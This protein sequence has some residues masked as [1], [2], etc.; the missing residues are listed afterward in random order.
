[1]RSKYQAVFDEV[2][3][4][5]ST[6]QGTYQGLA[7]VSMDSE[8]AKY[9]LTTLEEGSLHAYDIVFVKDDDGIWRIRSY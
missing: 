2:V 4:L 6:I 1:M 8:L 7:S 3:P 5:F 9:E